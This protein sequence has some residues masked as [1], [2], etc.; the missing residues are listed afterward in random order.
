[1]SQIIGH[2]HREF[3]L[4]FSV[5]IITVISLTT[6]ISVIRDV[7]YT[8]SICRDP[9]ANNLPAPVSVVML[10]SDVIM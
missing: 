3:H 2:S 6:A 1:M 7:Y 4:L 5:N 8:C 9:D 10:G